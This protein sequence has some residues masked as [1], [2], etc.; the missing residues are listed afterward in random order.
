MIV[1]TPYISA[2]E[3]EQSCRS[4]RYSCKYHNLPD[5]ATGG[6][7][8]NL[9]TQFNTYYRKLGHTH[10][11]DRKLDRSCDADK[12]EGQMN[13]M[14]AGQHT[15]GPVIYQFPLLANPNYPSC[16]AMCN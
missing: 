15:M 2:V 12:S 14:K 3:T 4:L 8:N 7:A 1:L 11:T 10:I 16:F 9:S 6:Q 5:A 13:V